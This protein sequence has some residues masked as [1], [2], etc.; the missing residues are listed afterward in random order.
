M[1]SEL[2]VEIGCEEIPARFLPPT[3]EQL[4]KKAKAAFEKSKIGHSKITT[5]GTPRRIGIAVND[6]ADTQESWEESKTGPFVNKAFDESGKPTKAAEGFARSCGV[7]IE[8]LSRTETKKG[9]KLYFSKT[10]EG[11]DTKDVL[12]AILPELIMSLDFPRSMRWGYGDL[13]FAR[14]IHWV[15]SIFSGECVE[16]DLGGIKSGNKTRGTPLHPS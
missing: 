9:E 12:C 2:L 6:M 14:P 5:F 7:T 8:E 15:L 4:E 3:L 13:T 11:K 16:F 1:P 10:V